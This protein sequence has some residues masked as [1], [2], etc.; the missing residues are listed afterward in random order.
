MR[1]L[2]AASGSLEANSLY[3]YLLIC[4]HFAETSLVAQSDHGLAGFVAA[5]RPPT[6]M[7]TVFVWQ[8][9][10]T[11]K[12][13]GE[14]VGTKLLDTLWQQPACQ[15]VRYLEATVTPSNVASGK[16]F[17]SFAR[18]RGAGLEITPHFTT[19]HFAPFD[20]EEEELYRIGPLR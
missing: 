20:H 3:A 9:G 6:D 15:T 18:S 17:A 2:V 14:G 1:E 7:D 12:F 13:R 4:T 8:I 10:V 16:L 11:A 5:Y 19:E